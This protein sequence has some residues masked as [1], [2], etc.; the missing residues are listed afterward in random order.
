LFQKPASFYSSA[1]LHAPTIFFF[2]VRMQ[3]P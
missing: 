1:F 3:Q 2:P